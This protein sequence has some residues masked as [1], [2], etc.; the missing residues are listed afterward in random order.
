MD[1]LSKE[2]LTDVAEGLFRQNTASGDRDLSWMLLGM[3]C[4]SRSDDMRHTLLPHLCPPTPVNDIGECHGVTDSCQPQCLNSKT[5]CAALLNVMAS[6]F[7]LADEGI[8]QVCSPES[9]PAACQ[10]LASG[11][12]HMRPTPGTS[13][14][15][16]RTPQ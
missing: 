10:S 8:Q 12:H 5:D 3:A 16:A 13:W 9:M 2:Q 15:N 6:W 1:V 14:L 4:L 11:G 7:A